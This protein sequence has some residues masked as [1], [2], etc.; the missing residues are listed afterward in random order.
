MEEQFMSKTRFTRSFSI[1]LNIQSDSD[2]FLRF[3]I[4]ENRTDLIRRALRYYLRHEKEAK[5][6]EKA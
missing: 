6:E 5:A 2:L 3:A 4:E 1:R